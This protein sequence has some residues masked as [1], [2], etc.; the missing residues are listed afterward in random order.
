MC[1]SGGSAAW[2]EAGHALQSGETRMASPRDD[3]RLRAREQVGNVE[4]AMRAY[5]AWE[6]DL[7]DQMASDDDQRF[8]VMAG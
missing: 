5:L 1:L 4:D 3:I 7:A 8:Q 6:I 2:V